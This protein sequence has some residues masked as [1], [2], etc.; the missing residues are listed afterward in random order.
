[1]KIIVLKFVLTALSLG[2]VQ[3]GCPLVNTLESC[4]LSKKDTGHKQGNVA[5]L[6][7]DNLPS[8]NIA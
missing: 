6:Q 1:M 2:M 8:L 7:M 5:M 4:S 3:V